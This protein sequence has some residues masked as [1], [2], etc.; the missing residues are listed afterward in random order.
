MKPATKPGAT[1]NSVADIGAY[2]EARRSQKK[3]TGGLSAKARTVA[4]YL[5]ALLLPGGS[6]MAFLL[7][8]FSSWRKYQRRTQI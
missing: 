6:V 1:L 5:A 7:W 4:P 8:L 2:R 3:G